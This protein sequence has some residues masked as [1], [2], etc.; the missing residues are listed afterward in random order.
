MI[1]EKL[2]KKYASGRHWDNHPPVFAEEFADFLITQR[3]NGLVVDVGC[4]NGKDVAAFCKK[5]VAAMG[6]DASKK[7]I[8]AARRAHP[9]FAFDQQDVTSL[10]FESDSVGAFFCINVLHYVDQA[11]AIAEMHRALMPGGFMFLH[12][13]LSITDNRNGQ[14]DFKQVFATD[15]LPLIYIMRSCGSRFFSRVDERPFR[16]THNIFQEIRQKHPRHTPA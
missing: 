5:G 12:F 4:G 9:S 2:F 10:E 11:R 7:E 1:N 3:L 16:H 6:I 13:N 15:I 14:V 8:D